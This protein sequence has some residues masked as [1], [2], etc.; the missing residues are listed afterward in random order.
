MFIKW[1]LRY[2]PFNRVKIQ[3]VNDLEISGACR[4]LRI[5]LFLRNKPLKNIVMQ[6]HKIYHT[7]EIY[8]VRMIQTQYITMVDVTCSCCLSQ[9]TLTGVCKMKSSLLGKKFMEYDVYN[10]SMNFYLFL[11]IHMYFFRII[12]CM[13][14]S[15]KG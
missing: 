8:V 10:F 13:Q 7:S 3:Y 1:T 6:T 15:Y 2:T 11:Y 9:V 12:A 14:L 4:L 5:Q